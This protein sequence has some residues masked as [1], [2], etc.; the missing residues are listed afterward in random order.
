MLSQYDKKKAWIW[1]GVFVNI[2]YFM[3]YTFIMVQKNLKYERNVRNKRNEWFM[4]RDALH[5]AIAYMAIYMDLQNSPA[6]LAKL[7]MDIK[8][9]QP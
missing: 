8:C 3:F 4:K 5:K 2:W 7:T 1:N 9:A 6:W